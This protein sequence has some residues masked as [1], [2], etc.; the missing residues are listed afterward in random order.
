M[1]PRGEV[2]AY[3]DDSDS[4]DD[5]SLASA[6]VDAEIPADGSYIV[7]AGTLFDLKTTEFSQE[8]PLD[9]S[10]YEIMMT[11]ASEVEIPEGEPQV[12]LSG[13]VIEAGEGGELTVTF[14]EPVYYVFFMAQEGQTVSL[15][16]GE[17]SGGETLLSDTLLWVFDRTGTRFAAA[18]DVDDSLFA[19]VEFV[20]EYTGIYMA[21]A[22]YPYF[23]WAADYDEPE[24]FFG[25]GTF[26]ISL[27]AE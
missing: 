12:Q 2:I 18:D 4:P 8:N 19:E 14:E 20:A 24:D 11:G 16:T 1:G 3:N 7:V 26:G 17:A 5:V 27:S 9:E 15:E 22:A 25:A 13:V 23:H 21:F 6:I 10:V